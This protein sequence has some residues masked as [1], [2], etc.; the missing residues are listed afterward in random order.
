MQVAEA[1]NW[2]SHQ[3]AEQE[4]KADASALLLH[5]LQKPRS[6]LFTWPDAE[7]SLVHEQAFKELVGER[8][9]GVPVAHLTGEREFWSLPLKV[10][11]STLIPRPDTE[12]MVEWALELVP[13]QSAKVMDLGTGT[14]AIA[15]ALA[16]ERPAWQVLALDFQQGAVELATENAHALKLD[17]QVEVRKSDWFTKV[18]AEQNYQMI[19]SNPPYIEESDPHLS[20]GDVRFEPKSALTAGADGLDDIRLLVEQSSDYLAQGGWLLLEHGYNQAEAVAE[21]FKA[22]GFGKVET[23]KDLGGQPRITGGQWNGTTPD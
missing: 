2:A 23:R 3:L 7:L 20:Q 15:L 18:Q 10:N 5:V 8:Q 11:A 17:S 21:L 14:G 9:K 12:T 6:Y 19:L 13:N 1:L 4:G 22:K 16:S